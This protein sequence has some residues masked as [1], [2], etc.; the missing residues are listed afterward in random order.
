MKTLGKLL[1]DKITPEGLS[2]IVTYGD[3]MVEGGKRVY[4][5]A[6]QSDGTTNAKS[7]FGMFP[8]K[9]PNDIRKM[10]DRIDE[11][12]QKVDLKHSKNNFD[13]NT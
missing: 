3:V 6:T 13:L 4:Y 7:P 9:I 8:D 5:F 10:S 12:Y 2:T 1:D 11:Y